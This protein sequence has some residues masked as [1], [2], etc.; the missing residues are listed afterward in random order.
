MA[1]LAALFS[2]LVLGETI[3]QQAGNHDMLCTSV[4]LSV[5]SG[6]TYFDGLQV[7]DPGLACEVSLE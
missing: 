2:L 7:A 6:P 3:Y 4:L 5:Y 1:V